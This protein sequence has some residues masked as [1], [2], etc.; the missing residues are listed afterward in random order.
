[1]L[2]NTTEKK[3][4]KNAYKQ[5]NLTESSLSDNFLNNERSESTDSSYDTYL[6]DLAAQD[7][8]TVA[9]CLEF[10]G[11]LSIKNLT[12][13]VFFALSLVGII[14][15]VIPTCSYV[16]VITPPVSN[17]TASPSLHPTVSPTM[18]GSPTTRPTFLP[19]FRPTFSPSG[20]SPHLVSYCDFY[21]VQSANTSN[22]ATCL[23]EAC[24]NT[25]L[26]ISGCGCNGDQLLTL[27]DSAGV[28]VGMND[29]ANCGMCS[30][31]RYNVTDNPSDVVCSVYTIQETCA[32]NT[33]YCRGDWR[34]DNSHKSH[35]AAY[36]TSKMQQNH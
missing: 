12:F 8:T 11:N 16:D 2:N 7:I 17:I 27:F 13:V 3:T 21:S 28:E 32:F 33:S 24:S 1:M 31:I 23:V 29:N 6:K 14:L 10:K 20:V 36:S 35:H 4:Q 30:K 34:A 5:L 15:P 22:Y 18:F 26:L 9:R 19:S 25:S